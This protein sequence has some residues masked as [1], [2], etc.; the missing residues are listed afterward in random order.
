M[1]MN[2]AVHQLQS[3]VAVA[4]DQLRNL[5]ARSDEHAIAVT[6]VGNMPTI[7][8]AIGELQTAIGQIRQAIS[9]T[10]SFQP[11]GRDSRERF[12]INPKDVIVDHFH[13][14]WRSS[15]TGRTMRSLMWM[16]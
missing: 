12:L 2:E 9:I 7:Q 13:G 15:G 5:S 8:Q 6:A 11:I 14:A 3:Q 10:S 16:S 4:L 1:D